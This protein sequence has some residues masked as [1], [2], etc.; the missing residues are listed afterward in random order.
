VWALGGTFFLPG[1]EHTA[2]L[3]GLRQANWIVSGLLLFGAVVVLGLV[4]PWGRRLPRALFL[5]PVGI[6]AV[7]CLSHGLFGF[8]TKALYLAGVHGA[9]SWPTGAAWS[10]AE[11]TAAVW[12]DLTIFEPWF[13]LEGLLLAAAGRQAVITPQRRRRWTAA[14]WRG[15]VVLLLF[16]LLLVLSHRRFAIG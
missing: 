5:V 16:G 11:R 3:P 15:T 2:A 10:A 1:G 6:A 12:R 13:V 7:V 9:V 4:R 8:A 14:M